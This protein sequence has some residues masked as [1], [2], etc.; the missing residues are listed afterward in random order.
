[1]AK[2]TTPRY[3]TARQLDVEE[4]VRNF[5]E[6]WCRVCGVLELLDPAADPETIETVCPKTSLS[7]C[8]LFQKI[9]L[10]RSVQST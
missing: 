6:T 9:K 7:S 3:V 4:S 1:M 10:A 2:K 8:P 5:V